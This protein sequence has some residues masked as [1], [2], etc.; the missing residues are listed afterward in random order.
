MPSSASAPTEL[1]TLSLHDAL[2]ISREYAVPRQLQRLPDR[3]RQQQGRSEGTHRRGMSGRPGRHV[4]VWQSAVHVG[5]NAEWPDRLR[6][7]SRSEEHTSELQSRLHLVC[8]LLLRRPPSSTLFPYTTLFRS[9]G[10][11]LFLGNFNGFQIVD[12]S[13]KAAPKV[14]TAVVCPGG[15]GDMSVYGN[16]LF[17]SV[18]MPN[19]RT[20]CGPGQDRKSTRLNSSHGYISYAVF[21]FGAHRA[22]H[23]FPTRRS[24]DLAGIRCSSATSTA[25]R[26]STS[27]TRPLRRYAPPWYVRAARATCR[28]MAICCSC[29]W[30]C[31]MAGPTAARV[32][33]GRAHV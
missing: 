2:P 1:Y 24:S 19:G 18:E 20:D 30:K 10:N 9:R 8:R 5:G 29:R 15:Q 25:S 26:S 23:S 28:C 7:G 6:P 21:C 12:V 33:I 11:T 27:A 13:N 31:R 17:M 14:R 3:R 22:L 32:K 16:L 4:G